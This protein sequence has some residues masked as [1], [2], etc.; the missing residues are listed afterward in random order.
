MAFTKEALQRNTEVTITIANPAV[1][2]LTAHGF[3]AGDVVEFKTTGALPTGLS[4][5][6]SYYVI[7]TGLTSDVFE[8][9]ATL[10]GSAV[11]TS[12]SQSGT[13]I[14]TRKEALSANSFTKEALP[15]GE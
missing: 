14:I 12:G 3:S 2:S 1:I 8:V 10:A 9:S 11:N 13:H 4:V 15:D 7:S 6:T 5:A